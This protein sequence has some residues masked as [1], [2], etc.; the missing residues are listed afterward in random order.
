MPPSDVGGTTRKDLVD[1]PVPTIGLAFDHARFKIKDMPKLNAYL[2]A[3][4]TSFED[5]AEAGDEDVDP[6]KEVS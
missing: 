1:V 4:Q 2:N 6:S 3:I 5:T